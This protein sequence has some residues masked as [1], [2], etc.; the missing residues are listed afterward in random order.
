ML[1]DIRTV[2][3]HDPSRK[4]DDTEFIFHRHCFP[5]LV[6]VVIFE[7]PD[8]AGIIS[9]KRRRHSSVLSGQS[10]QMSAI[11]HHCHHL[12]RKRQLLV[13]DGL[14]K[15]FW[16][17]FCRKRIHSDCIT[18][19][20]A[21]KDN[22]VICLR[23]RHDLELKVTFECVIVRAVRTAR[24]RKPMKIVIVSTELEHRA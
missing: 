13:T 23:D 9:V 12:V 17:I 16:S 21:A 4:I 20:V 22:L 6:R 7:C 18:G 3:F 15:G 10:A 24:E 8:L 11:H 2:E 19:P 1:K 5:F 14:H